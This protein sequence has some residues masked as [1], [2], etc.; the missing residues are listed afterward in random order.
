VLNCYKKVSAILEKA[1]AKVVG[2]SKNQT[3]TRQVTNRI[4][5]PILPRVIKSF[6]IHKEVS[7]NV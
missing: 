5:I 3:M 2:K 6:T 7:S 1:I 4:I